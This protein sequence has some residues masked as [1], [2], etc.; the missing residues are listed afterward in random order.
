MSIDQVNKQAQQ[1][2]PTET[3]T[4]GGLMREK[5]PT[6]V[7]NFRLVHFAELVCSLGRSKGESIQSTG[8]KRMEQVIG[9]IRFFTILESKGRGG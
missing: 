4:I 2:A 9:N 8:T 7:L 5:K 6:L 3:T 1:N